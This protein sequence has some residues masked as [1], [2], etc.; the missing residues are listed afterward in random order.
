MG[1]QNHLFGGPRGVTRRVWCFYEGSGALGGTT[2]PVGPTPPQYP[3]L[4]TI[5]SLKPTYPIPAGTL[6]SMMPFCG[7]YISSFENIHIG[8]KSKNK[9][10]I[11][12]PCGGML[13]VSLFEK[14]TKWA[15]LGY[16]VFVVPGETAKYQHRQMR[17][18]LAYH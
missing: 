2:F 13:R 12:Y 16:F 7:I 11:I 15:I 1:C 10:Y 3:K 14:T 17:W 8:S 6:A 5:P 18:E 4:R 9:K